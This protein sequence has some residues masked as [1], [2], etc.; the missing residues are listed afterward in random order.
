MFGTYINRGQ[1]LLFPFFAYSIDN[2]R[3][4]QPAQLGFG[5]NEDFR[6]KF[7]SSESQLFIA[8]GVTDRLALEFEAAY[9]TATLEK[10]PSD[11][12]ATPAKTRQ[13]GLADFEGQIRFLLTTEGRGR[14]EIFSFLEMTPRSQR[15][16]ALIGEPYWDLKPGVGVVRGFSF[17]TLTLRLTGEWNHEAKN[18]DLGEVAVEYLK[19]LSPSLRLNLAVEGGE[20]GAPDEFVLISGVR[21]RISD[22]LALKLDNS[23][24]I[25]SKATDW[26]P[27]IGLMISSPK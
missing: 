15:H 21:W 12:S 3:E 1:L 25:S 7:H 18:L 16:K 8:Y 2:N 27:Q 6:G 13:S 20:G 5:L 10:S 22:R 11:P 19:R 4:Y 14:P 24:G 9:I 26:A 17:G 23:L